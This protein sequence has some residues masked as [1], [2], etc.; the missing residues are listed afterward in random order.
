MTKNHLILLFLLLAGCGKK[1]VFVLSDQSKKKYFLVDSINNAYAEEA[2][3]KDPIISIN[4]IIFKYDIE[5]DTI[6][7]PVKKNEI[8]NFSVLNRNSSSVIFGD[9][10]NSGAI[11]I[12]TSALK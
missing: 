12:N 4:G 3:L 8:T 1:H 2:I 11:I 9:K 10:H 5:L 7:L 6:V